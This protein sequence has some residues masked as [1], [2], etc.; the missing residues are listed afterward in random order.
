M[1]RGLEWLLIECR[2][3]PVDPNSQ[4]NQPIR[5][6][7]KYVYGVKRGK[8]VRFNEEWFHCLWPVVNW[9]YRSNEVNAGEF[10]TVPHVSLDCNL[11]PVHF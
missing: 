7:V 4:V 8:N 2:E 5:T 1:M 3:L 9:R 11:V 10:R 6:R